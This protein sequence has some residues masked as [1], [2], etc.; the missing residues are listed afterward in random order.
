[1]SFPI[2]VCSEVL[3]VVS[4]IN[5]NV[6]MSFCKIRC[7]IILVHRFRQVTSLLKNAYG[8]LTIVQI[9]CINFIHF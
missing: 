1:M 6:C 8:Y 5:T 9:I 2:N 3:F 4:S 7:I